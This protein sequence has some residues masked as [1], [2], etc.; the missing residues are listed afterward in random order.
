MLTLY[1]QGEVLLII[2][3]GCRHPSHWGKLCYMTTPDVE[4]CGLVKN[5]ASTGLVST[6]VQVNLVDVLIQSGMEELVDN[7]PIL[8]GR[9]H[10]VFFNGDWVGVCDDATSLVAD[11]RSKRR[12]KEV[13]YQVPTLS[14]S[15]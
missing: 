10:K 5:L 14:L 15:C 3:G 13:H 4:N 7:M 9:K 1:D 8:L 2:I 12:S 6:H 11:I